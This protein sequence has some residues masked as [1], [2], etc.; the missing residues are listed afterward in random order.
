MTKKTKNVSFITERHKVLG[1]KEAEV[2]RTKA[3]GD[4]YQF[5]M[6]VSKERKYVRQSLKTDNLQVALQL[7]KNKALK[8]IGVIESGKRVFGINVGELIDLFLAEKRK[9]VENKYIT[10]GRWLI[11]RTYLKHFASFIGNNT[12]VGSLDA[13]CCYDYAE[14]RR[15]QNGG[16]KDVTIKNEKATINAMMKYAHKKSFT[17]FDIFDFRKVG[18]EQNALGNL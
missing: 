1:L 12:S 6:W 8:T 13:Q 4:I 7:A 15:K 5:R 18:K 10:Q 11:I 14:W 2:L 17:D 3:S 16:A 9:D